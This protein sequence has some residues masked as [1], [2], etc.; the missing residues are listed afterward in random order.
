M[1]GNRGIHELRSQF[2]EASERTFLILC[3]EAGISDNVCDHNGGQLSLGRRGGLGIRFGHCPETRDPRTGSMRTNARWIV[4]K[5]S[6]ILVKED[7]ARRRSDRTVAMRYMIS[8]TREAYGLATRSRRRNR[9]NPDQSY[10][11]MAKENDR[12][13]NPKQAQREWA[14]CYIPGQSA[15]RAAS[16]GRRTERS[17]NRLGASHA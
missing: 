14:E 16:R 6:L 7:R 1:A 9:E 15:E 2:P 3:C 12:D 11:A 5:G 17:T 8:L 4:R 13:P 10:L